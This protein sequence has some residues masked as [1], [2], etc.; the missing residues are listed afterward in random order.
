MDSPEFI[1]AVLDQASDRSVVVAAPGR[2][3]E[4][5]FQVRPAGTLFVDSMGDV[6]AL[7]LGIAMAARDIDVYAFETDGG[8][9][10]NLSVLPTLGCRLPEL[11]NLQVA[12]VD[13]RIYE[14]SG[15]MPSRDC[16]LEWE[17]LFSAFHL[18]AEVCCDLEATTSA[19]TGRAGTQRPVLI[20]LVT[21]DDP[22]PAP[23]KT[24]DGVESSYLVEA[25]LARL[26]GTGRRRPAEKS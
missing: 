7:A 24:V 2:T 20:G 1:G 6:C 5:L 8:I 21:N 12:I 25:E 16:P 10:M 11:G 9:L 22:V 23:G 18:R 26:R 13:N 15:G 3:G 4:T 17:T 19:I 14:S